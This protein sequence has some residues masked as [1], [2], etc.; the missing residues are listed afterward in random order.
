MKTTTAK[1]PLERSIGLTSLVLYGLGVT[2]GAGIYVLIGETAGRAGVFAPSSFLLAAFIMVF[3]AASFAELST[4]IPTAAGDAAYVDA[5]FRSRWLT[6]ATGFMLIVTAIVAAAAIALGCAGYVGELIDWPIELIATLIV[7]AMG[8]L[9]IW[10]IRE[11]VA[12]AAVLTV[13]EVIGLLIIIV[14]G[15]FD[16]PGLLAEIPK[17]LPVSADSAAFTGIIGASLLA[18][19]AF[20]GFE[21]IVH[22]AEEAKDPLKSLPR[23]IWITL[24]IV[25]VL[26]FLVSLVAVNSLPVDV[27]A[28]S[29]API[30]LLFE[31]LA[32]MSPL[33]ITLIAIFATMNG[34]VVQIVLAARVIYGL[35]G[36]RQLPAFLAAVNP[37]TQTPVLATVLS[38]AMVIVLAVFV[39]L[40][41]LAE[42]TS[43]FVL[44]IFCM[45]N[46]SLIRIKLRREPVPDGVYVVPFFIPVIGA[47]TSFALLV[48][49]LFLD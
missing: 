46:L 28:G 14:L 3:S 30:G 13:L 29:K 37:V 32:G 8:G 2:V 16:N 35:A 38:V 18:F 12:F 23:A 39:E 20:I 5:G 47:L 10:G 26:Y 36:L 4:R 11:S 45:V 48:A 22:I 42:W 6:A 7:L 34:V 17:S 1:V 21:D 33:L 44:G 9:S 43:L 15:F 24:I 49:P 25:T 27:L 31:R 19:F 40:G 41:R